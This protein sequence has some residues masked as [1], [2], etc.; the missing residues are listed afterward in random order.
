MR[1][2]KMYM[3]SANVYSHYLYINSSSLTARSFVGQCGFVE[4]VDRCSQHRR[5]FSASSKSHNDPYNDQRSGIN[6][7]VNNAV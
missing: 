7:T 2:K 3:Q 1:E 5:L 4:I 6:G